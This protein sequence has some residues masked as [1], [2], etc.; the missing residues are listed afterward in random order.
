MKYI[1]LIFIQKWKDF[2]GEIMD[3]KMHWKCISLDI[4]ILL[5]CEEN[6]ILSIMIIKCHEMTR[7]TVLKMMSVSCVESNYTF[8]SY[9]RD[10]SLVIRIRFMFACMCVCVCVCACLCVC[11]CVCMC[12]CMR[13]VHTVCVCVYACVCACV[14]VYACVCACVHVHACKRYIVG[15]IVIFGCNIHYNMALW[16]Y[17][18]KNWKYIQNN[19]VVCVLLFICTKLLWGE[20]DAHS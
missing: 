16:V 11:V 9:T 3:I 5:I 8:A 2:T 18:D 7:W 20:I 6:V 12:V 1:S 14:Y 17:W 13:D 4:Y 19:G 10:T 15:I